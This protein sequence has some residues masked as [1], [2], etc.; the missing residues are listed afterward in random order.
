MYNRYIYNRTNKKAL[1]ERK[2]P[3]QAFWLVNSTNNDYN[4]KYQ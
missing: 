4:I 2:P 3:S 1:S